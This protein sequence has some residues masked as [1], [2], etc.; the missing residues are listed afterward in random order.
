MVSEKI[1]FNQPGST[2]KARKKPQNHGNP[3]ILQI[4][5]KLEKPGRGIYNMV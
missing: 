3:L 1:K 5:V 2:T 4:L